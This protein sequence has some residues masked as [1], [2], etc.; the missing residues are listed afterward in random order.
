MAGVPGG[1]WSSS[2]VRRRSFVRSFVRSIVHSFVRS[3]LFEMPFHSSRKRN[4]LASAGTTN[5]A[6]SGWTGCLGW[7]DGWMAGRK[8]QHYH[9]LLFLRILRLKLPSS[10][11]AARPCPLST[12]TLRHRP[13]PTATV[14]TSQKRSV[15]RVQKHSKVVLVDRGADVR[16]LGGGMGVA[17][18]LVLTTALAPQ[19][20]EVCC[21]RPGLKVFF[22]GSRRTKSRIDSLFARTT[23]TRYFKSRGV[24][25]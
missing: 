24:I 5:D 8:T 12:L 2:F 14:A 13:P 16:V 4:Q 9:H 1:G 7:Q 18:K 22:L 21:T 11:H 25:D 17:A 23:H 15:A 10:T 6:R 19:A 20:P 3:V